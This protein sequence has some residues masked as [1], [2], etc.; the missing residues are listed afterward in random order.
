M[1]STDKSKHL[2]E[3]T[4]II[5]FL[6]VTR[7]STGGHM[8]HIGYTNSDKELFFQSLE[9]WIENSKDG[10]RPSKDDIFDCYCLMTYMITYYVSKGDSRK[11]PA[12]EYALECK[13]HLMQLSLWEKF[14]KRWDA[15]I[16]LHFA[17]LGKSLALLHF[18]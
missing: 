15:S 6:L 18:K 11:I 12:Y 5:K 14:A 10:E 2:L 8:L 4:L 1:S 3:V 17:K 16:D 13:K 7:I 9:S